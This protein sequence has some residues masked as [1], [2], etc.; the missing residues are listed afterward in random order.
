[1]KAY[2]GYGLLLLSLF[3]TLSLF[4]VP[5]YFPRTVKYTTRYALLFWGITVAIFFTS[6]AFM[7]Y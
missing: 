7:P 1:M 3:C 4:A 2:I 5:Y 6:I